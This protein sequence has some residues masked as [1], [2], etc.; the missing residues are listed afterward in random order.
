M[1]DFLTQEE[2]DQILNGGGL[3]ETPPKA[4]A[5]FTRAGKQSKLDLLLDVPVTCKVIA[6]KTKKKLKDLLELKPGMIIETDH[7]ISEYVEL[8]VNDSVIALGEVVMVGENYGLRIKKI[9][10]PAERVRRL[11]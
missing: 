11:R 8:Y 7:N 4:P 9:I 10:P 1:S 2:I 5:A 6:G 3:K